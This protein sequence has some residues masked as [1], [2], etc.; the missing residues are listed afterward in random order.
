MRVSARAVWGPR[1]RLPGGALGPPGLRVS[2]CGTGGQTAVI[3]LAGGSRCPRARAALEKQRGFGL[4]PGELAARQ[5]RVPP[6]R[7]R[8]A[9][10]AGHR[11]RQPENGRQSRKKGPPGA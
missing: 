1:A 11:A 10:T 2:L 3:Q 5:R 7:G 9:A 6:Q 4:R 8:A